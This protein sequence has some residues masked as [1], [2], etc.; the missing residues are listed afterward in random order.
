MMEENKMTLKVVAATG[1]PMLDEELKKQPNMKVTE[2][3]LRGELENIID[4]TSPQLVIVSDK[5]SGDENTI[6]M[7]IH[8]KNKYHFVR[9]IYLA[10]QFDPRDK[11]RIDALG[12]LVLVGIYDIITSQKVNIDVIMDTI[13]FPKKEQS[14]SYL[15]ANLLNSKHEIK[16]I[17]GGGIEYEQYD[18]GDE[19]LQNVFPNVYMFTSVKPG[20]GK[21]FV[22]TNTACAIAKYGKERPRV[23][24]IEAD[25]QTLSIGTLLS[26]DEKKGNLKDVMQAISTIFE[27][28]TLIDDDDRKRKVNKTIKNSM[29]TYKE[30]PNLDVLVGSSITP[31]EIDSLAIIP[32]YFTYI[33]DV[34]KDE[35]DYIIIDTNSSIFHVSSFQIAQK[36]KVCYYILNLDFNNVRNNIRYA[37]MLKEIG[38][39]DKVQYILNENIENTKEYYAYGVELEELN[40]TSQD[41]ENKYFN[42]IAKIPMLPKTIF[43]NRLYDGIPVVLDKNSVSYTNNVK[44][45]L[46]KIANG[47]CPMGDEYEKLAKQIEKSKSG[48]FFQRLM[49]SL[50][51]KK[52][53][54]PII[55]EDDGDDDE[56][57]ESE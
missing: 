45:E 13:K 31:E 37:N 46:M 23:A 33:L 8:L 53:K 39:F 10:G 19:V 5:L 4:T 15:T 49:G 21:S 14:V 9:F 24:L 22:A 44:Y 42:L 55:I 18:D 29:V 11:G 35:Y 1:I 28:K 54:K 47:I 43:L 52:E 17:I 25:M 27:K 7:L 6:K 30:I 20:T 2:C 50:K 51:S 34:L 32:E 48:G 56:M 57:T 38:I 40:F 12:M 36:S 41:I 26:I 16:N 3:F